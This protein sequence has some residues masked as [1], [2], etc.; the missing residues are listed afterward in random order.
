MERADTAMIWASLAP[1]PCPEKPGPLARPWAGDDD[2]PLPVGFAATPLL[3]LRLGAD[4]STTSE[5][6]DQRRHRP[7][8]AAR[9]LIA[10]PR[11]RTSRRVREAQRIRRDGRPF[12][13]RIRLRPR[14]PASP[15]S[16]APHRHRSGGIAA[17]VRRPA[18]LLVLPSQHRP[19]GAR[20]TC[21]PPRRCSSPTSLVREAPR[22]SPPF[23]TLA[24]EQGALASP[25][26]RAF[27]MTARAERAHQL[28]PGLPSR[29]ARPRR[30]RWDRR[31][32][33]VSRLVDVQRPLDMGSPSAAPPPEIR[34]L[35]AHHHIDGARAHPVCWS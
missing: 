28:H 35:L 21:R 27:P 16:A 17:G 31:R 23:A 9:A 4:P 33:G 34:R 6:I 13:H 3:P 29:R 20:Q 26:Y 30:V 32:R 15:R 7:S 19:T 10:S 5:P 18:Q 11:S 25:P 12:P 22:P 24:G 14:K 1:A 2:L 8:P